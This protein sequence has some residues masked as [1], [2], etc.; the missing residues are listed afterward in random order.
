[1]KLWANKTNTYQGETLYQIG[2]DAPFNFEQQDDFA[3]NL[4]TIRDT[5]SDFVQ[6]HGFDPSAIYY[7]RYNYSYDR[8]Y[9]VEQLKGLSNFAKY[10]NNTSYT[11]TNLTDST[12]TLNVPVI[13]TQTTFI[14]KGVI[15]TIEVPNWKG[16][17]EELQSLIGRQW[18]IQFDNTLFN[19][20]YAAN[21]P[22]VLQYFSLEGPNEDTLHITF[23]CSNAEYEVGMNTE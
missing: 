6:A 19:G 20:F 3:E 11:T 17:A 18:T 8:A 2:T 7:R 15:F 21:F 5:A 23:S 4:I 16:D 14:K 9:T 1:M 13:L 22:L 10:P 12:L